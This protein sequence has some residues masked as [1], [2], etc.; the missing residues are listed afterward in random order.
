MAFRHYK[1]YDFYLNGDIRSRLSP[2]KPGSKIIKQHI[3]RGVNH[4]FLWIDKEKVLVVVH[5]IMAKLFLPNYYGLTCVHHKDGNLK[6]NYLYNLRFCKEEDEDYR[7]TLPV[8]STNSSGVEGVNFVRGI[9]RWVARIKIN[10][11]VCQRS[12]ESKEQAI[13]YR[14]NLQLFSASDEPSKPYKPIK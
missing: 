9:N 7:K 3:R 6:N 1:K 13:I 11:R 14:R 8:R 12:Y 5:E 2:N 4:A 10:G